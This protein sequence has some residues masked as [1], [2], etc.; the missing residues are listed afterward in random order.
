VPVRK[1]ANLKSC[2][3]LSLPPAAEGRAPAQ[4]SEADKP[5]RLKFADQWATL[6]DQVELSAMGDNHGCNSITRVRT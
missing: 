5:L 6:A 2:R 1:R 4:E 3:A